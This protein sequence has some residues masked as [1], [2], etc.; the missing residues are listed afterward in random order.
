MWYKNE[1]TTCFCFGSNHA[2][3]RR[4]DGRTEFS[5][6]ERVCIPC[7]TVKWEGDDADDDAER[8]MV[9]VDRWARYQPERR[10]EAARKFSQ[11]NVQWPGHISHGWSSFCRRRERR[12]TT[13]WTM[14]FVP[15]QRTTKNR[16]LRHASYTGLMMM[17]MMM[18]M[19][20][21]KS[22]S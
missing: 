9:A 15:R 19:M 11:G 5:W 14:S 13:V 10:S 7:S 8:C 6:L 2:F 12:S 1:G 4:T 16:R 3:H 20:V 22:Y 17:M 21:M 18:M